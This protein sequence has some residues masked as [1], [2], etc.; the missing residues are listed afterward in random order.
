V[1]VVDL[2]QQAHCIPQGIALVDVGVDPGRLGVD[3]SG[4]RCAD[5]FSETGVIT[6]WPVPN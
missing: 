3:H 5:R 1:P 6:I 4:G 2:D